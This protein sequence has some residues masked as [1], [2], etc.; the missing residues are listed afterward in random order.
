MR[1]LRLVQILALVVIVVSMATLV[2]GRVTR[3]RLRRLK[4][5]EANLYVALDG[6]TPKGRLVLRGHNPLPL[7]IRVRVS[8]VNVVGRGFPVTLALFQLADTKLA[9]G[10]F[11]AAVD[12]RANGPQALLAGLAG[13]LS[14]TGLVDLQAD[15]EASV[16]PLTRRFKV[17]AR[18][19]I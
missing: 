15:L 8:R 4:L 7:P 3:G 11:T 5:S 6:F 10:D 13:L 14:A 17:A 19:G 9:S 18:V 2:A 16:G 12:L 1:S